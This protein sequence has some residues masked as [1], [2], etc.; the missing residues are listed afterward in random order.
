[1]V[2]ER[3]IVECLRLGR[4]IALDVA[5]QPGSEYVLEVSVKQWRWALKQGNEMLAW[6]YYRDT[7]EQ[8]MQDYAEFALAARTAVVRFPENGGVA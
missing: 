2:S 8:A 4:C 5:H 6:G 7:R 1:M 3:Q